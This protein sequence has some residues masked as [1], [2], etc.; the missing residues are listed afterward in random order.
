M[1]FINYNSGTVTGYFKNDVDS[2]LKIG[3]FTSSNL[4]YAKVGAL[5]KFTAP[6]G[7]VFDVNNNLITG[8]SGTINT[9]DYIWASISEVVTDGTNQG[10]GN[11]ETGVGPVTL[12]EVIPQDA[13]LDQV[14]A[15]WNTAITSTVRNSIIQAIG[16]FKTFG[17]RYDRDTQAWTIIDALDLNQT[18]TFSL[19]YAGNTSNT[20]LDAS[21]F[22][23][24][25]N[26]GSTYTVDFRSTSY[27]FE[28]KLE[29]RFY[30]DNDLKI[31][32]PRTGK[33]IKD[34]VNI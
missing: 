11:L 24:F 29:T 26:D 32:D 21:W 10:V 4:K 20:N 22:F 8:T 3:G 25:T 9:R 16:D 14:I 5:L 7:K 23:K 17:L 2:P 1:E 19:D 15:P 13:V 28:S 18:T 12:S 27:V 6:S 33:T 34:K 31:F 30:F